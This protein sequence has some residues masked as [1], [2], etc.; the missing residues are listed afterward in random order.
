MPQ[1]IRRTLFA[2]LQVA[3]AALVLASPSLAIAA[4]ARATPPPPS[5]T[6]LP[7]QVSEQVWDAMTGRQVELVLVD[8]GLV[9]GTLT[10][11]D[12]T[13]FTLIDVAGDSGVHSKAEIRELRAAPP[14]TT[15][16]GAFTSNEPPPS[17]PTHG[18]LA[19]PACIG[20]RCGSAPT[21][22]T[23]LRKA[24]HTRNAGLTT[25]VVGASVAAVG[26]MLIPIGYV[27]GRRNLQTADACAAGERES[28]CGHALDRA[29]HGARTLRAGIAFLGMGVLATIAGG[30]TYGIANARVRK[31]K[32]VRVDGI[33]LAP[34]RGGLGLGLRGRF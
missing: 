15:S 27:S 33:S 14:H 2:R 11:H 22:D 25:I 6:P 1:P 3:L 19:E 13:T 7:T 34:S 29:V 23:Q 12:D 24:E 21:D 32:R 20:G 9:F 18:Q 5:T 8:G 26:S 10:S 4:P 17:R 30:I 16:Q 28:S 31:A